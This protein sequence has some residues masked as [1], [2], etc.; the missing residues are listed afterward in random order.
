MAAEEPTNSDRRTIRAARSRCPAIP[1]SRTIL[2]YVP[3]ATVKLN[4]EKQTKIANFII[5]N[6]FGMEETFLVSP[7]FRSKV[8]DLDHIESE[9]AVNSLRVEHLRRT[10]HGP[11]TRQTPWL[12][13]GSLG[14]DIAKA[15]KGLDG[16][17][18]A[19][20]KDRAASA[21][22]WNDARASLA[23]TLFAWMEAFIIQGKDV[24][25]PAT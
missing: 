24:P 22:F 25:P 16:T 5:H 11:A 12:R 19:F 9:N 15:V 2:L 3:E 8:Q 21:P 14:D 4:N 7:L 20:L 13:T 6:Y 23:P 10:I 1:G 18:S 17:D